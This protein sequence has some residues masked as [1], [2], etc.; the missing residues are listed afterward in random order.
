LTV[1]VC[2]R[3]SLGLKVAA[4]CRGSL[5]VK[6]A[7]K[8]GVDVVYHCDFSDEDAIALLTEAKDRIFVNP[9]VALLVVG[10][11]GT[12]EDD[13]DDP[14]AGQCKQHHRHR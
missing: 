8:H 7:V 9:A 4:H 6:L 12:A 13:P 14:A 11:E 3:Q 5:D 10:T 1:R 2:R